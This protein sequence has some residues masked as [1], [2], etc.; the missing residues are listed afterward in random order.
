MKGDRN[1][2]KRAA[3]ERSVRVQPE[4]IHHGGKVICMTRC[5]SSR[6]HLTRCTN[7]YLYMMF[8]KWSGPVIRNFIHF[9]QWLIWEGEGVGDESGNY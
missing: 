8:G 6:G 2:D 7:E 4:V 9:V 3:L 5:K 1:Q